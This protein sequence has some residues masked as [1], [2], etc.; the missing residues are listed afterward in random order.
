VEKR[1]II[2]SLVNYL[3]EPL[4]YTQ[5]RSVF[6]PEERACQT[7]YTISSI[8]EKIPA[9][10]IMLLEMGLKKKLPHNI[11]N[12]VDDYLY[13]GEIELVRQA[14]DSPFKGFGEAVGLIHAKRYL[15]SEQVF[16]FKISGRYFLTEHFCVDEW[17]LQKFNVRNNGTDIST[18]LYGF[19]CVFFE[20]YFHALTQSLPLLLENQC[21]EHVLPN[22]IPERAIHS[23]EHLGVGGKVAPT[24]EYLEE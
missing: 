11:G 15:P 5:V 10:K 19:P 1:F 24:G 16:Y 18:R 3:S 21:I 23:L 7:V 2:T 13:L 14:C 9:A 22:F 6:S 17:N 4:S 20:L 12:I 8:R